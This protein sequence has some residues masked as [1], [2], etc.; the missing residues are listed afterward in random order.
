MAT[1][2]KK[3][4][5]LSQGQPVTV[6]GG[7]FAVEVL[8][9]EVESASLEYPGS[10]GAS[11]PDA[12]EVQSEGDRVV[13]TA[14]P[15]AGPGERVLRLRLPAGD[16]DLVVETGNGRILLEGVSGTI[17][18]NATNGR[19]ELRR[20]AGETTVV[21]ANGSVDATGAGGSLDLST[22][23]GRIVVAGAK[24]K[25]GSFKSGNGRIGVQ[26]TPDG[27]GSIGIFAGNGRVELAL[28]ADAGFRIKV[29]TRGRLHNN[30]ESYSVSSDPEATVVEKGNGELAVLI[31]AFKGV[32]L[33]K[34]EDFGKDREDSPIPGFPGFDTEDMQDLF[35]RLG[36]CFGFGGGGARRFEFSEEIPR[37][38]HRM[39]EMGA[40]FGRMGEEFSRRFSETQQQ[41]GGA[42]RDRGV[43][44]ILDLLKEGKVSAEEAERLINA[45][46]SK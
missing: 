46:R 18:A 23:N 33:V 39:R 1:M 3:D 13:I 38:A 9:G 44:M 29:K 20:V 16:R 11:A 4:V 36:A 2:M 41:G 34:Y 25:S 5:A 27:P 42:S 21:C 30:L 31:Q 8:A 17:R 6:R 12:V 22:A 32:R 43:D 15:D 19:V 28:P 45:L 10:E 26:L 40:R 7:N 35:N 24:L 14:L 37:M